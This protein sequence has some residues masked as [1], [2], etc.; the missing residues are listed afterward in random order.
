MKTNI[1][2][3]TEYVIQNGAEVTGKMTNEWSKVL[4]CEQN[5]QSFLQMNVPDLVSGIYA[6]R[7]HFSMQFTYQTIHVPNLGNS[8]IFEPKI[9]GL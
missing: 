6:K 8:S 2:E 5:F 4:F 9:H 1:V 3:K 7:P